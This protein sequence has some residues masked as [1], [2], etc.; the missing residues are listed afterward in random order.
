[1]GT[2]PIFESDFDCLTEL[3]HRST[4]V[5]KKSA[6]MFMTKKQ[7]DAIYENLFREGVMVAEKICKRTQGRMHPDVTSVSNLL[8]IKACQSLTS[9]GLVKQQFAWRHYYWVLT[10]EGIEYLRE[11]LHLPPEIVPVTMKKQAKIVDNKQPRGGRVGPAR[12]AY[13]GD[14]R[15]EYRREKDANVGPGGAGFGFRGGA[16]RGA[17]RGGPAQ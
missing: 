14:Q 15:E 7:R 13:S 9:R 6:K 5:R 2:H 17:G 1:M 3:E 10:T 4:C 8:V 12:P 11:Y 16:G